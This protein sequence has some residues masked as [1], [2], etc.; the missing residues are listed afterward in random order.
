MTRTSSIDLTARC[1]DVEQRFPASVEMF[2]DSIARGID[3]SGGISHLLCGKL[4]VLAGCAWYLRH[5]VGQYRSYLAEIGP[6]MISICDRDAVGAITAGSLLS[7]HSYREM[8][9]MLAGG[10]LASAREF[11]AKMGYRREYDEKHSHPFGIA[12]GQGIRHVVLQQPAEARPF[13]EEADRMCGTK[14]GFWTHGYTH[15]LQ[16]CLDGDLAMANRA[17]REIVDGHPRELKRGGMF[18][19]DLIHLCLCHWGV[20]VANLARGIYDLP[21]DAIPPLIPAELLI[22]PASASSLSQTNNV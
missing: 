2:R 13:L 15:I 5:D 21:V 18:E 17:L 1:R 7:S 16:A 8:M 14:K 3:K 11:A 9:H 6:L 10:D 4:E 20:A 19:D 12:F 22:Q